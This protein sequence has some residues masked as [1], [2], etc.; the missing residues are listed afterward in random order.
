MTVVDETG[1]VREQG[2]ARLEELCGY[3]LP[4]GKKVSNHWRCGSVNGEEASS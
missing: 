2:L 1:L 3:L 4:S